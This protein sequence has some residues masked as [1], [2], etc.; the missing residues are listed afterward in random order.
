MVTGVVTCST[1]YVIPEIISCPGAIHTEQRSLLV[2]AS[3]LQVLLDASG[4]I[5][6]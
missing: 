3:S 5:E 6:Y 2:S 4:K 1:V